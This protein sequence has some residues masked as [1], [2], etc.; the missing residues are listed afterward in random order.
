MYNKDILFELGLREEVGKG[1]VFSKVIVQ[2][3][4]FFLIYFLL[5]YMQFILLKPAGL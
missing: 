4:S 5:K 1:F 2:L 3:F